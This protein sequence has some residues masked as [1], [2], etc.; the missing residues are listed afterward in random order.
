MDA[1]QIEQQLLNE[2]RAAR[3]HDLFT[4]NSALDLV[5]FIRGG[6]E[7]MVAESRTSEDDLTQ[8][9]QNLRRFLDEMDAARVEL[10]YSEFREDTGGLARRICPLWPFCE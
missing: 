5:M 6:A 4:A 10:G 8:A 1:G 3:G 2:V 7:T 9:K